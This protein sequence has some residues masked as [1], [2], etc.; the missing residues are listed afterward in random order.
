MSFWAFVK[1]GKKKNEIGIKNKKISLDSAFA[2]ASLSIDQK[3]EPN[4]KLYKSSGN[5]IEVSI[6]KRM[7][8]KTDKTNNTKQILLIAIGKGIEIASNRKKRNGRL[9]LLSLFMSCSTLFK[10]L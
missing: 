7:F 8:L 1:F 3:I 5:T 10:K 4:I 2:V 6:E 9:F